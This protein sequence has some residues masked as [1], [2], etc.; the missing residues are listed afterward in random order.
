MSSGAVAAEP[1]EFGAPVAPAPK[2]A[3]PM[4][5]W[6]ARPGVPIARAFATEAGDA[7]VSIDE[8]NHTRLW[9]S[10]DGKREPW[11]VPLT[12][13]VRIALQHDG[14]G[15]ALA[16]LDEAGGLELVTIDA[17]GTMTT[18]VKQPPDPGFAAV[19]ANP[20][21]FL[22]LR[23][24]QT[25]QQL[26][27][28]GESRATLQAPPGEHV[29]QLL[30]RTGRT[31]AL[32]RT[33]E[34]V[35][36]H[37]LAADNL[38]WAE[39]TP[40]LA[41][42]LEHV[43]LSP[44]HKRLAFS[45]TNVDEETETRFVDL[46]TGRV[47]ALSHDLSF[48]PPMGFPIGYTAD[49]R[50]VIGFSD[51]ELSTL[52]WWKESGRPNASIGGN[53]YALEF[54][55]LDSAVVTDTNVIAIS[56][57]ELAIVTANS[58]SA[59][60]EVKYLGYRTPRAKSVKGSPIGVIA[61][62][63][64]AARLLDDRVHAD[65]RLPALD[66]VPLAKDLALVKFTTSDWGEPVLGIS[67]GIDPEWLEQPSGKQKRSNPSSPRIA[68]FDLDKKKELQRWPTAKAVRFEPAS[69][70]MAID[71]GNKV[72][73]ARFD[74]TARKLVDDK[75]LAATV[76]DVALLDPKLADGNVAMLVRERAGSIELRALHDLDMLPAA[77]TL[78]GKLEAIDRAGRSYVREDA[79]TIV[80]HAGDRE[81]A[82]LTGLTGWSVR[83][84]PSGAQIVAFAKS[85]LMLLDDRGQAIW[86]VGFPGIADVAWTPDG[87]LVVLAGDLAKVDVATGRVVA[88]QCGWGF[89]LRSVH[90]EVPDVPSTTETLCDQ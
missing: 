89:G 63:A 83:P 38:G 30:H 80:V 55:A 1:F 19:I 31:L 51:F 24:D 70:L 28:H 23:R 67:N 82:R 46:E 41:I 4:Q 90:P 44:D 14:D 61:T 36:G 58:A 77:T 53:D 78:T 66:T 69:G 56:G 11:V 10:L 86:S 59:P 52:V 72:M 15:F 34:G 7:A 74:A 64:G 50:I 3:R 88:A 57:H 73:F 84:S 62:I 26:D 13:P 54:V 49:Q 71:R 6:N 48:S 35:R 65:Q 5:L 16:S 76:T 29:L 79:D 39:Q 47:R 85:R 21:G 12:M 68:L 45:A 20:D 25:L 9:P 8:S 33:K 43:F 18:H 2:P 22:V 81:T 75:T 42:N 60:T 87:K 17:A 37:W 32:V 27:R 40:K